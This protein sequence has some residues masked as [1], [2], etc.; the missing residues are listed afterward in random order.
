MTNQYNHHHY[1]EQSQGLLGSTYYG[2]F[3]KEHFHSQAGAWEETC[4]NFIETPEILNYVYTQNPK[5]LTILEIGLGQGTGYL[6]LVSKLTSLPIE[7]R[8]FLQFF[9]LE[10]FEECLL[11]AQ[12]T[13]KK[14][15]R[16]Q[17]SKYSEY[18]DDSLNYYPEFN[19]QNFFENKNNKNKNSQ[20][21]FISKNTYGHLEVLWGNALETIL[22]LKKKLVQQNIN[23]DFIFH[24]PFSPSKNP[25]LWT[26]HWFEQLRSISHSQTRLS[27]YSCSKVTKKGLSEGGWFYEKK[28]GLPPKREILLARCSTLQGST[29][30]K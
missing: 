30:K 16:S 21:I 12:E 20:N 26:G 19:S 6:T 29:L 13:E 8:P 22:L 9:S 4:H 2:T 7:N 3:F 24:D 27:T 17:Y 14:I 5:E 11:F 25:E 10:L 18:S 23:I 1:I 28:A 15:Q